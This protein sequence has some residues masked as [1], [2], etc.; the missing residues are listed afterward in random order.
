MTP[1]L[2]STC[3]GQASPLRPRRTVTSGATLAAWCEERAPDAW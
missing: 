3:V 2:K 1:P